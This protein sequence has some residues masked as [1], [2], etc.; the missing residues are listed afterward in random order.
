M[1]ISIL[2]PPV[3][4]P[5]AFKN[6]CVNLSLDVSDSAFAYVSRMRLE[7]SYGLA[8]AGTSCS[9]R[10]NILWNLNRAQT[11]SEMSN[12]ASEGGLRMRSSDD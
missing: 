3:G 4:N 12:A 6:A 1:V 7:W 10:S 8:S 2:T 5:I 9:K 11:L